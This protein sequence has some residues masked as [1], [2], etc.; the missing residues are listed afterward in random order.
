LI[1]F[2][3]DGAGDSRHEL[4]VQAPTIR[5]LPPSASIREA[6]RGGNPE[7]DTYKARIHADQIALLRGESQ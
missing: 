3:V 1:G 6:S 7:G 2:L 4:E 5:V